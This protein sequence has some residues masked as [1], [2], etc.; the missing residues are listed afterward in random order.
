MCS[1]VDFGLCVSEFTIWGS[2]CMIQGVMF[3]VF[4]A[5]CNSHVN[6]LCRYVI[7]EDSGDMDMA[8]KIIEEFGDRFDVLINRRRM[9]QLFSMDKA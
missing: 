9:G 4:R 5:L 2:G 7:I 6:P 3:R 8:A 1:V